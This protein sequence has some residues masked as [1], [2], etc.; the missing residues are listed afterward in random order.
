MERRTLL[1]V[2]LA[3]TVWYS[4]LLL[5]PPPVS[6]EPVAPAVPVEVVPVAPVPTAPT[7]SL[8]D[9]EAGTEPFVGCGVQGTWSNAG[10][11]LAALGRRVLRTPRGDT[12][13]EL[14]AGGFGEWRPYGD[15]PGPASC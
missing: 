7:P 4:W 14:G 15:T 6:E 2:V 5:F 3:L 13:L 9:V 8:P 11:A 1:F 12:V 10:E